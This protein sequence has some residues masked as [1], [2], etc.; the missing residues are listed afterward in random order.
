MFAEFFNQNIWLFAVLATIVVLLIFSFLNSSVKG[1]KSV[2]VLEMPALQRK[3]K[4]IIIDVNKP[5][6]F[7]A[8]HI[9]QSVN[10]PLEE[11]NAENSALLK[12]KDKTAILV[13]QTGSRSNNAAKKLVELGFTNVNILRG[14]LISWT[15]ENLPIASTRPSNK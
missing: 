14:G 13:C 5:E 15:K 3:G 4:S 8:T 12:H 7:T 2:S 11:L 6:H 9:P 1:A 10:F